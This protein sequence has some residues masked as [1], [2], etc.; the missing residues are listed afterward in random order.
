M[1]QGIV[2]YYTPLPCAQAMDW[3]LPHEKKKT[4]KLIRDRKSKAPMKKFQNKVSKK[5]QVN[6]EDDAEW[7]F[8]NVHYSV[9][10][11]RI[12]DPA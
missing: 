11:S 4:S 3:M 7:I 5:I 2:E 1:N 10:R 12:L 8:C 6:M 9:S